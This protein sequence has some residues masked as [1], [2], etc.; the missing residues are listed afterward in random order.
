[1][2]FS[3]LFDNKIIIILVIFLVIFSIS[4]ASNSTRTKVGK[5][6][7]LYFKLLKTILTK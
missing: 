2:K 1:Q 6:S 4:L 5:F 7:R 3:I